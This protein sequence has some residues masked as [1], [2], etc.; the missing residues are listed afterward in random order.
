MTAAEI[1][2]Q[3]IW[4]NIGNVAH[5]FVCTAGKKAICENIKNVG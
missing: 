4:K 2:K 1:L 3:S 5:R